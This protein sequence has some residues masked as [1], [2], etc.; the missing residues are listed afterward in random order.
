MYSMYFGAE[1]IAAR[2]ERGVDQDVPIGLIQSAIGGSQIERCILPWTLA[3][4]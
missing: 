2:R 3:T 4:A 1:L